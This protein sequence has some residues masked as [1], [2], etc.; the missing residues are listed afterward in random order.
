MANE[1]DQDKN[2]HTTPLPDGDHQMTEAMESLSKSEAYDKSAFADEEEGQ[3]EDG[4]DKEGTMS[5][6]DRASTKGTKVQAPKEPDTNVQK[7]IHVI[8]HFLTKFDHEPLQVDKEQASIS[9]KYPKYLSKQSLF[10]L[11]LKDYLFR[12]VFLMQILIFTQTLQQPII[13]T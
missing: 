4:N 1:N 2:N 10:K 5:V 12:E 7:I 3:I 13:K 11:Q 6:D 9:V 8:R